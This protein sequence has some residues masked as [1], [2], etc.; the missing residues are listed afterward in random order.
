M[1][2]RL[3]KEAKEAKRCDQMI[4]AME[5]EK[6]HMEYWQNAVAVQILLKRYKELLIGLDEVKRNRLR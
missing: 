2:G 4:D 5:Q 3:T 6:R 1:V